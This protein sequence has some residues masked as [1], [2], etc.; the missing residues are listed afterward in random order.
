MK[1]RRL[2]LRQ[3]PPPDGHNPRADRGQFAWVYVLLVLL[4][5]PSAYLP[6]VDPA[7]LILN[8]RKLNFTGIN[9]SDSI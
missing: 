6:V 5:D 9:T 1:H 2:M 8:S 4:S 7:P 3:H